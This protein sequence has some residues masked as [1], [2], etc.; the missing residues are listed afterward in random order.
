MK[1]FAILTSV[2]MMFVLAPMLV[3]GESINSTGNSK[4]DDYDLNARN[5]GAAYENSP[6]GG[7]Q[8]MSSVQTTDYICGRNGGGSVGDGCSISTISKRLY[9]DNLNNGSRFDLRLITVE[10]Y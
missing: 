9:K 1:R 6:G 8:S 10:Y 3:S 4:A 2:M 7:I 5:I